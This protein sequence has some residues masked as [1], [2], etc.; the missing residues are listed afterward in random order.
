MAG[1]SSYLDHDAT[2]D[3]VCIMGFFV[4]ESE[5]WATRL[6]IVS[7]SA[8]HS[9]SDGGFGQ[10]QHQHQHHHDDDDACRCNIESNGAHEFRTID[11]ET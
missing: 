1:P 7:I 4:V 5:P 8:A 2:L 6:N 3:Q 9:K 11:L 10:H